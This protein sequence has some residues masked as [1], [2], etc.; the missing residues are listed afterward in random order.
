[1]KN[2]SLILFTV[3]I[4]SVNIHAQGLYGKIGGSLGFGWPWTYSSNESYHELEMTLTGTEVTSKN[5][6]FGFGADPFIAVG[7]M[8][9]PTMGAEIGFGNHFGI[10]RTNENSYI[11]PLTRQSYRA[12][13]K[14]KCSWMWINPQL[15]IATTVSDFKPYAKVGVLIGI[16]P[17]MEMLSE[18]LSD[19]GHRKTE[20]SGGM[21]WGFN[22]TLGI[23]KQL[24][25][26]FHLFGELEMVQMNYAPTISEI[27]EYTDANGTDQLPLLNQKSKKTEFVD[28]WNSSD[29]SNDLPNK[30]AKINVPLSSLKINLGIRYNF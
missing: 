5:S 9:T 24:K 28:G 1:M 25:N 16:S 18:N 29:L 27:T 13:V 4:C 3:L 26:N 11:N 10:A 8:F 21:P 19:K 15:V 14:I 22:A 7:Y 2:K 23:S 6:N 12:D 20:V 17:K 30:V